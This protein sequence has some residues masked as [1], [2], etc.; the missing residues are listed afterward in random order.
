[1]EKTIR[2]YDIDWLRI[3]AIILLLFFHTGMIFISWSWYFI[4]DTDKSYII[5]EATK[6]LSYWRM[7]LLFFISGAG[8][9]FALGIRNHF[10]YIKERGKKLVLPLIFGILLV[11]PPQIYFE[12]KHQGWEFSNYLDFN[13]L[14]FGGGLYH[15]G[16]FSWNHLWFIAYLFIYSIVALPV[17]LFFRS[18][19]GKIFIDKFASVI[20]KGIRINL[21]LI[22]IILTQVFL[23]NKFSGFHNIVDDGANLLFFFLFF[24]YGYLVCSNTTLWETLERIRRFSLIAG[25]VSLSVIYIERM[26]YTY[27]F[28]YELYWILNSFIVWFFVLAVMGYGRRYLNFKNKFLSYA[29]EGIY[30]FYILHQTVLIILAFYVLQWDTSIAFKYVTLSLSTIAICIIIYDLL[31]R[32]NNVLRILF[33]MKPVKETPKFILSY[34]FIYFAKWVRN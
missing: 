24:I 25:I 11:I 30:P 31:I 21:L 32:R 23:R 19:K 3:I 12:L 8:T 22:P 13:L 33:G 17:F 2:R 9:L 5:D 26:F 10:Q 6:F 15:H 16:D 18:D 4:Q 7:P 34:P 1:M 29:N 14:Y 28:S 20:S 27:S